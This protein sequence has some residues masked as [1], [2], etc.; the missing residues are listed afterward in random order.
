M[1][2]ETSQTIITQ[3]MHQSYKALT[4][5]NTTEC[6]QRRATRNNRA[7]RTRAIIRRMYM[8]ENAPHNS[9]CS[10]IYYETSYYLSIKGRSTPLTWV[11]EEARHRSVRP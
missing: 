4:N 8:Y 6:T 5:H 3:D 1:R 10:S 7:P 9:Y 11:G 2:H